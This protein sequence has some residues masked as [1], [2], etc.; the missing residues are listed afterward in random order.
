[1]IV[2]K[3]QLIGGGVLLVALIGVSIATGKL[4]IRKFTGQAEEGPTFERRLPPPVVEHTE[5]QPGGAAGVSA[6]DVLASVAG[7]SAGNAFV[8]ELAGGTPGQAAGDAQLPPDF[9]GAPGGSTATEPAEAPTTP[10]A[11]NVSPAHAGATASLAPSMPPPDTREGRSLPIGPSATINAATLVPPSRPEGG[12]GVPAPVIA[13]VPP[14]ASASLSSPVPTATAT[15]AGA[16]PMAGVLPAGNGISVPGAPA[17]ASTAPPTSPADAGASATGSASEGP[18]NASAAMISGNSVAAAAMASLPANATGQDLL[19]L[20]TQLA[21]L[22]KQ[23][24]IASGH[25]AIA[26]SLLKTRKAQYE[27]AQIGRPSAAEATAQQVARAAAV[28]PPPPPPSPLASV[29]LLSTARANGSVGATISYNGKLIDV[30]KG[31]IVA[32]YVVDKVTDTSLTLIGEREKKTVWI[33]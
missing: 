12:A 13:P 26:E 20:Q 5:V 33:D 7:D 8:N 11:Q 1:M 24:A 23:K 22:D 6:D 31:S 18:G 28:A 10:A 27:M 32:G 2:D 29:R 16:I 19:T 30:R 25:E 3:K 9:G 21:V 4:D 15:Q 17:A 14:P